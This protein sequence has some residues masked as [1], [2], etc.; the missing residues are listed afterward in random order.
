RRRRHGQKYT[1]FDAFSGAGGSSRGA[2]KAG[3]FPRYA[4]DHWYAACYTY[5]S[6]LR[7]T[8][9]FK[10]SADRVI[11]TTTLKMLIT[12]VLHLSPPCQV[13]SPAHTIPSQARD[14]ANLASLFS[15]ESL[16]VKAKPRIFTLEQTF[17]LMM[18]RFAIYFNHLVN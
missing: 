17:G 12:D 5:R 10:M 16:L 7:H 8:E 15:C 9:L 11:A 3:L 14:E 6:N 2:V 4:V 13:F 1:F 18:D